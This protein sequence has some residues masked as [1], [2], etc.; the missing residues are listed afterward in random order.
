MNK[1]SAIATAGG[2]VASFVAGVAAVSFNWGLTRPTPVSQAASATS[3]VP[4]KVEP[5]IKH[6]TITIHKKAP[7]HESTSA[8]GSRTVV[9]AAAPA[10][11][12]APVATTSASPVSGGES[13]DG[14]REGGDD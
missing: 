2:L 7:T 3:P 14:E 5:I 11:A 4:A 6:R 12:T 13:D 10:P 8:S 1:K 9:L